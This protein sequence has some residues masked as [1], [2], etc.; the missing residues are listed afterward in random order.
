VQRVTRRHS[1][2]TIHKKCYCK[3]REKEVMDFS[4]EQINIVEKKIDS[5]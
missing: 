2:V 1:R 3:E 5:S 4:A